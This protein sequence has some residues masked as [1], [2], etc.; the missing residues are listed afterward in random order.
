[1]KVVFRISLT[2]HKINQEGG[3]NGSLHVLCSLSAAV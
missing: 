3:G 1:M 2:Y